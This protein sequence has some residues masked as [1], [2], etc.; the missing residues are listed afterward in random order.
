MKIF[1]F[2]FALCAAVSLAGC[3]QQTHIEQRSIEL[4]A[5]NPDATLAT[6]ARIGQNL[7]ASDFGADIQKQFPKLSQDQLRGLYLT[8]NAGDFQGKQRVFFL[9]G[10]RYSG[11]LP[12]AKSVADYC[13]SRVKQVVAA[14][15]PPPRAR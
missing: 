10:I 7:I 3:L 8:W 12:E 13:E 4:P 11:D 6:A 9:T 5:D 2:F 14:K 15:F 1:F